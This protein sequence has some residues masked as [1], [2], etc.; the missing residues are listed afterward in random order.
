MANLSS[1]VMELVREVR[2][3]EYEAGSLQDLDAPLYRGMLRIVFG[4]DKGGKVTRFGLEVGGTGVHLVG[5][6][7]ALDSHENMERFFCAKSSWTE[8]MRDLQLHGLTV[9][10]GNQEE[11]EEERMV[12]VQLVLI[13]DKAFISEVLG[14]QGSAA[15]FPITWDLTPSTHLRKA[16]KDGSPHLPTLA[17]CQF[18]PRTLASLDKDYYESRMDTRNNG[19][20]KKN[21]RFHH[22]V[23]A[24]RL[25]H[26]R[27]LDDVAISILHHWLFWGLT[28]TT[29]ASLI[30]RI[31]DGNALKEELTGV[32]ALVEAQLM[33]P[34]EGADENSND[35]DDRAMED[36]D[37]EEDEDDLDGEEEEDDGEAELTPAQLAARH[38][39]LQMEAAW[40]EQA[41]L[42]AELEGNEVELSE[43]LKE[44]DFHLKRVDLLSRQE[45]KALEKEVK[46]KYRVTRMDKGFA[47]C[48]AACLLTRYDWDPAL[49]VCSTCNRARHIIC[50]VA[51][52]TEL[53]EEVFT[54]RECRGIAI[55]KDIENAL[56]KKKEGDIARLQAMHSTLGEARLAMSAKRKEVVKVMG[57]Q[58]RELERVLAEE[59][60]VRRTDYASACWVGA[61]VDKIVAHWR[62]VIRKRAP[63]V[64]Q[65]RSFLS[66]TG[67]LML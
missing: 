30:C 10:S 32:A 38:H 20:P 26:L 47:A 13:G 62:K 22:S 36:T 4:G 15:T 43:E 52:K 51:S 65:K 53:E 39:R 55:L 45:R 54:C 44:A 11:E 2:R 3:G 59:V 29:F 23:V 24:P 63:F 7:G 61:H 12:E 56:L 50:E 9:V 8:Q 40:T 31:I 49:K 5:A 66:T 33:E 14:L 27:S 34:E 35:Q 16:H 19:D 41:A 64:A 67:A 25:V 21:G 48:G 18:E 37:E 17:G 6:F 60:G 46:K 28:L 42:V 57:K 1:L 58:E